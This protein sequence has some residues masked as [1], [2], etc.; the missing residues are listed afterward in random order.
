MN[1]RKEVIPMK[2]KLFVRPVSVVLPD[3][4]FKHIKNLTD[5]SEVSISD[6]IR[7]AVQE[8]LARETT[9]INQEG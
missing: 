7:D 8:K 3:E 1:F 4:M 5:R 6:Y 2:K 9:I